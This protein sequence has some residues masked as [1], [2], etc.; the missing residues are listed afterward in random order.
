MSLDQNLDMKDLS[1][2]STRRFF[3]LIQLTFGA[4]L[5]SCVKKGEMEEATTIGHSSLISLASTYMT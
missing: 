2:L 4:D 1:V 3:H 5:E